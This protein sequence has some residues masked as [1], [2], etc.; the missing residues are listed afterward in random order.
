MKCP[1]QEHPI[2]IVLQY[3]LRLNFVLKCRHQSYNVAVPM[4]VHTVIGKVL[5]PYLYAPVQSSESYYFQK[6]QQ[7][8]NLKVTAM[9]SVRIMQANHLSNIKLRI[10]L[11]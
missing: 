8:F 11:L 4:K 2:G 1:S 10:L 5:P 6:L 3:E 7:S 9:H